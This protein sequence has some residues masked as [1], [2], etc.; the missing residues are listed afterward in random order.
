MEGGVERTHILDGRVRHSIVI[1]MLSDEG[2]GT[3]IRR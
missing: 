2:V 3:M 1:E